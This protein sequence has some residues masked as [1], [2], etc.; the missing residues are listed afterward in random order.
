MSYYTKIET[1]RPAEG[2][3]YGAQG[4]KEVQFVVYKRGETDTVIAAIPQQQ[5][6]RAFVKIMELSS[7]F[8]ML[9]SGAHKGNSFD[10]L[11][12]TALREMDAAVEFMDNKE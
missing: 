5:I 4:G 11:I 1:D 9:S 3:L 2:R 8:N 12:T 10:H 7:I 6:V